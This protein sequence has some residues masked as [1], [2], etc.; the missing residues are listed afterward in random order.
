MPGQA[1]WLCAHHT[2]GRIR[3]LAPP[4]RLSSCVCITQ[5][6]GQITG[7]HEQMGQGMAIFKQLQQFSVL[8]TKLNIQMSSRYF[9][10]YNRRNSPRLK[11]YNEVS[12]AKYNASERC[13]SK[14][15]EPLHL[16]LTSLASTAWDI[17]SEFHLVQCKP[18]NCLHL[19]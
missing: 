2:R 16:P 17:E 18:P 4:L 9:I 19:S 5:N 8:W 1:R 13:Q 14:Y 15:T 3:Q 6:N 12:P 11:H 7:H 10:S